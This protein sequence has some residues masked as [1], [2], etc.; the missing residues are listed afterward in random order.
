MKVCL[1]VLS[2]VNASKPVDHMNFK[3]LLEMGT[4]SVN[5]LTLIPNVG[6]SQYFRDLQDVLQAVCIHVSISDVFFSYPRP[7]H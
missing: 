6:S 2:M 1:L 7:S 5:N 3:E 4:Y